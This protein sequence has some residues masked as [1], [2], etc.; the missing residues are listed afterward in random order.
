[1]KK[2]TLSNLLKKDKGHSTRSVHGASVPGRLLVTIHFFDFLADLFSQN[3][4][5]IVVWFIP[6]L[7]RKTILSLVFFLENFLV[8]VLMETVF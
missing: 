1:M 5:L 3:C 8:F 4:L 7:C 6:A 2:I